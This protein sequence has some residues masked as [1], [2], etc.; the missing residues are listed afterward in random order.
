MGDQSDRMTQATRDAHIQDS[1]VHATEL[2]KSEANPLLLDGGTSLTA[3]QKPDAR[4]ELQ[5][6]LDHTRTIVYT[7]EVSSGKT[8][9]RSL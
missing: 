4:T 3:C 9:T 5:Q 7:S 2:D 8:A 1:T 6:I